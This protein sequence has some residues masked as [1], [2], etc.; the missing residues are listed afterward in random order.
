MYLGGAEKIQTSRTWSSAL[1]AGMTKIHRIDQNSLEERESRESKLKLPLK[2][3]YP[4]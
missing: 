2:I 4:I 3:K 1:E